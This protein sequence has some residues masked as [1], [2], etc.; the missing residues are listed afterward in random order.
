MKQSRHVV[1]WSGSCAARL[2]DYRTTRLQD[3]LS[4]AELARLR[5]AAYRLFGALFLYPDESRLTALVV[6]A[7]ALQEAGESLAIFPFFGSWQRLLTALTL[8]PGR[9]RGHAPLT[10]D[11]QQEYVHLFLVN[12][13]GPLCPPY[14]SFYLDPDREAAGWI[15]AQL[16][17]EYAT[18]GLMLSPRLKEQPD[19]AAVELEFMAYLCDQEAQAWE[20]EVLEGA[21]QVLE[22]QRAFLTGHLGRWFPAFTR[23]LTLVAE[24]SLYGVTAAA[25]HAFVHHDRDLVALLLES[26]GR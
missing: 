12:P 10:V 5:Q 8:T 18:A 15:P 4:L 9:G 7:G 11:V 26:A 19:H 21:F 3:D 2:R 22:R 1:A 20:E 6:A 25:A 24:E 13:D 17:R 16:E 23:R 14:E